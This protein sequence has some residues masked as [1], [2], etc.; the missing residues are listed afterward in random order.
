MAAKAKAAGKKKKKKDNPL[1]GVP[2]G[3]AIDVAEGVGSLL[4]KYLAQRYEVEQKVEELKEGAEEKVEELRDEAVKTGYAVKK[5][6]FRSIVEAIILATGILSLI[7]GLVKII[8]RV[9]E[10][11][12][13]LLLYG[14]LSLAFLAIQLK[15][16]P[17]A[18]E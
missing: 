10:L 7:Y 6:F 4:M 12:Y 15:M 1:T 3:S 17:E 18:G 16:A 5:A 8:G 2:L 14:V 13:V 11:E 9:I